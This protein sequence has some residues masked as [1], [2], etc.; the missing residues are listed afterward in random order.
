MR[1]TSGRSPGHSVLQVLFCS[2]MPSQ[3]APPLRGAGLVQVRERFWTPRPQRTLQGDQSLHDDQPPFTVGDHDGG[4]GAAPLGH[5]VA[6]DAGVVPGVGEPGFGDDEV[7]VASRVHAFK[8][9]A[10]TSAAG[11]SDSGKPE[12]NRATPNPGRPG[13]AADRVDR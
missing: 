5:D 3:K 1:A 13:L 6:G 11:C 7:V 2:D 8:T 12:S 4:G 10:A 9:D